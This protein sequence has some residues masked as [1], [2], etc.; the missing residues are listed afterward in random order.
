MKEHMMDLN[1]Q[2]S[3]GILLLFL[4]A[5][6]II[7]VR[8]KELPLLFLAAGG[9]G[10]IVLS[11]LKG[12]V[13][14]LQM[15]LGCLPGAGLLLAARITD[16]GVGYGDGALLLIPGI[17]LGLFPVIL[18]L[19]CA[20]LAAALTGI[21]LMIVKKWKKKRSLPFVPFLYVGYILLL[22]MG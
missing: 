4:C 19:F 11:L 17:L 14:V 3:Q 22:L 13:S 10:A 21:F 12:E 9:A 16:Q 6:A 7:D 2:I 5:A 1:I 15:L 8:T 18:L 20:L